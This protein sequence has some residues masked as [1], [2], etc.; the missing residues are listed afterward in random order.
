M[1]LAEV[2]QRVREHYR[3]L[4]QGALPE[5]AV[6]MVQAPVFHGYAASVLVELEKASSV[7]Q[8]ESALA[9]DVIEIADGEAEP[10][11]NLSATGQEKIMVRVSGDGDATRFW[12]WVAVDNLK[13][14][15]VNAISCALELSRLRPSGKV[16]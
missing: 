1:H 15:A 12:L 3:A 4:S 14:T 11:S 6:Q 16:Q 13:L 2:G 7:K 5:L 9:G 8:V 10:P